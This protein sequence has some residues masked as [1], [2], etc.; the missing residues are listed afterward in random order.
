[1]QPHSCLAAPEQRHLFLEKVGFC[2]GWDRLSPS[3]CWSCIGDLKTLVTC[4]G[5][6]GK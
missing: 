4:I 1:M 5:S 2:V 3:G 6:P